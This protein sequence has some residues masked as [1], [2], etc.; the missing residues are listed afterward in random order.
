MMCDIYKRKLIESKVKA[1][2]FLQLPKS[3]KQFLDD[4]EFYSFEL[5]KIEIQLHELTNL[6]QIL[7][8]IQE[9]K[10]HTLSVEQF[11]KIGVPE[12]LLDLSS[13]VSYT[14][15]SNIGLTINI[16]YKCLNF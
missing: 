1:N 14:A 6:R 8:D 16:P 9:G 4:V 2:K 7:I 5:Q 13:A 12:S 15:K 11:T 10:T 3:K